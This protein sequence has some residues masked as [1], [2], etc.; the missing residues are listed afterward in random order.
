MSASDGH[1][2]IG[3]DTSFTGQIRGGLLVEIAGRAEGTIVTKHLVINEGGSFSGSL[4]TDSAE[5]H[6]RLRGDVRVRNLLSIRASGDVEGDIQYGQLALEAGSNLVA[7]LRNVPPELAGDFELHVSRGGRV[8]ITPEDLNATD[9]DDGADALT[10]TATN[11]LHGHIAHADAPDEPLAQ[12]TQAD[13][14]AGTILFVHS[15]AETNNAGFDVVVADAQG[16]TA[17]PVRP[18]MVRVDSDA[19]ALPVAARA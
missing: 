12:F 10:F 4:R 8:A 19:V 18:V 1:M 3:S 9:A 16:A 5:V 6:G 15:G 7:D 13:I 14:D 11:L 2:K 17:G